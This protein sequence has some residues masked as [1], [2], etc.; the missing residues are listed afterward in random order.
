MRNV[1][2]TGSG[3][4]KGNEDSLN[5][6]RRFQGL[7]CRILALR[8]HQ[9]AGRPTP[10]PLEIG[11][12]EKCLD[13]CADISSVCVSSGGRLPGGLMSLGPTNVGRVC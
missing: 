6:Q 5:W 12:G 10:S 8:P 13:S 11:G 2:F 1:E 7:C 3:Q 9:E 4:R